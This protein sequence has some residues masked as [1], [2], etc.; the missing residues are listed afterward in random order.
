ML[1]GFSRAEDLIGIIHSEIEANELSS[2]LNH[3]DELQGLWNKIATDTDSAY[4][5]S[6]LFQGTN[7]NQAIAQL[8]V[9]KDN[10]QFI[11]KLEYAI[12]NPKIKTKILEVVQDA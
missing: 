12:H 11:A 4:V 2:A 7:L 5:L 1:T 8:E 9:E 10:S 6:C 3:L